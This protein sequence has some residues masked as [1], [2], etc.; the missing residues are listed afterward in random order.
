M[1]INGNNRPVDPAVRKRQLEAGKVGSSSQSDAAKSTEAPGSGSRTDG[2][3]A[4][5]QE[6]IQRYVDILK[7]YDAMDQ[8]K[9][10]ELR[11]RIAKGD[12]TMTPNDLAEKFYALLDNGGYPTT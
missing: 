3:Q 4:L 7:S 2:Y 6:E 11:D 1:E 5:S 10:E 9:I 12:Y 8:G